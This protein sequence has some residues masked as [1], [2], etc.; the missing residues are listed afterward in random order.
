M[1]QKFDEWFAKQTPEYQD[2]ALGANVAALVRDGQVSAKAALVNAQ[3]LSLE[4]FLK[5]VTPLTP[6]A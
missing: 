2:E 1:S 3:P 6:G 5:G 4:E